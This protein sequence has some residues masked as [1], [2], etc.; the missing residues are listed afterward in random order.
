MKKITNIEIA[1]DQFI[2]AAINHA[3]ATL[4]GDYKTVNKNYDRIIKI[5]KYLKH[6]N[7]LYI[8]EDLVNHESLGVRICAGT[9]LLPVNEKKAKET[10]EN[11]V[12]KTDGIHSLI[13]KTTLNEWEKG[14]L[15]I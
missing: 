9:Y 6:L 10:L 15:K 2:E 13:A 7:K 1:I 11:I 3:N 12:N 14:N 4:S 8:L 5:I